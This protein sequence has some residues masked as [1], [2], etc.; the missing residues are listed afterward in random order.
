VKIGDLVKFKDNDA[1]GLIIAAKGNVFRVQWLDGST[2]GRFG[3]DLEVIN[4]SR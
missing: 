1:T 3:D 4:E 2:N